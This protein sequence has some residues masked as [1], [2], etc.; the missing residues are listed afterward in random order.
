MSK[1]TESVENSIKKVIN[2]LG[3]ELVEVEYAKKYDQMNLTV[4]IDNETGIS[5]D[6]CEKVHNAIDP[7]LDELDPTEGAPYILNVSSEGLDRPLKS[8]RD[9]NKNM[10]KDIEISLFAAL[11]GKKKYVGTLIS[12][13]IESTT[14]KENDK[15]LKIE[16]KLISQILPYIKF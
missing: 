4:F 10:N 1:V 3:Y 11:N 9:F 14:I 16:N 15:I 8:E 6:D 7:V 13:D 12:R 2:D 5:L